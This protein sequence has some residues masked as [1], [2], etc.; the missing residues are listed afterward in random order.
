MIN[1]HCFTRDIRST[2]RDI[3]QCYRA[4]TMIWMDREEAMI[5][6]ACF[7]REAGEGNGWRE[8]LLV[9]EWE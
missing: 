1:C 7:G 8:R 4:M 9:F 6:G 2:L 5:G 3:Q